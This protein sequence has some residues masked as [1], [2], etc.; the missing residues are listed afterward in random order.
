MVMEKNSQFWKDA[1]KDIFPGQ[2]L[3]RVVFS[4]GR[5]MNDFV[6]EEILNNT[7]QNAVNWFNEFK[8][9]EYLNLLRGECEVIKIEPIVDPD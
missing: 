7:G 9:D 4:D 2:K 5:E 3:C 8:K 1:R 6:P